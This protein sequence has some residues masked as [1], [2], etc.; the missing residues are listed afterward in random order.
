MIYK[1]NTIVLGNGFDIDMGLKTSYKDFLR[2]EQFRNLLDYSN[3]FKKELNMIRFIKEKS[4]LETWGGVEESIL[5]FIKNIDKTPNKKER[6]II[7]EVYERL[8]KGI[9]EYLNSISYEEIDKNSCAAYLLHK[10]SGQQNVYSFNY[11]DIN[12]PFNTKKDYCNYLHGTLKENDTILGVQDAEITNGL[13]FVKKSFHK[14]YNSKDFVKALLDSEH[15]IF[16]GHSLCMSD[17]EYF[18]SL[19]SPS[20]DN[21]DRRISFIIYD[22]EDQDMILEN[23]IKISQVQIAAIR[24]RIKIDFYFTNNTDKE[25]TKIFIDDFMNHSIK[26]YAFMP[27]GHIP[28]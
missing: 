11:T 25:E 1:P 14:N 13:G 2:S 23:I 27:S 10:L 24:E 8:E 7:R 18:T 20:H 5:D 9:A 6:A 15:I 28:L 21:K 4:E 16:F 17:K 12:K 19:F 22:K 26:G 3:R